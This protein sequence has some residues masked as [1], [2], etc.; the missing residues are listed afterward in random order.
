M[1]T[2]IF[3][4]NNPAYLLDPNIVSGNIGDFYLK[5]S[6]FNMT[7]SN[8]LL[9]KFLK[10][11]LEYE[12]DASTFKTRMATAGCQF[13]TS[14]VSSDSVLGNDAI[15]TLYAYYGGILYFM[16]RTEGRR[17]WGMH[18]LTFGH[19]ED[20]IVGSLPK[21]LIGYGMRCM[22]RSLVGSNLMIKNRITALG[23]AYSP[24]LSTTN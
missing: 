24:P 22:S 15:Y 21:N 9:R 17:P 4:S 5:N 1:A 23:P 18:N 19:L 2:T 14:L 6:N 13:L 8:T 12:P 16:G 7:Y 20:N 11:V 3:L 10:D